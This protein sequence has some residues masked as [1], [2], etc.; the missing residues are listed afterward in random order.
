M[1]TRIQKWGNSLGLRIPKT[2]A[3]QAGLNEGTPVDFVIRGN[4]IVINPQ[5]Y[6]LEAMISQ[7]TPDNVHREIDNGD[8]AGNEVW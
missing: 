3:Q 2:I 6:S 5:R 8:I 1:Q 7:I 4:T